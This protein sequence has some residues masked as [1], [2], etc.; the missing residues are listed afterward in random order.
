MVFFEV[1]KSTGLSV[2]DARS[3]KNIFDSPSYL[4]IYDDFLQCGH[5][6]FIS[7]KKL[8]VRFLLNNDCNKTLFHRMFVMLKLHLFNTVRDSG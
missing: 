8:F 6:L 7:L 5:F 1:I 4:R 3:T 2:P